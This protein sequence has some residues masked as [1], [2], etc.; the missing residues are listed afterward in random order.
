MLESTDGCFRDP[1]R[2]GDLLVVVEARQARRDFRVTAGVVVCDS[3][4][5]GYSC[6][7]M[8]EAFDIL[9]R[10]GVPRGGEVY[11]L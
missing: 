5:Q 6:R 9:R 11:F 10:D 7:C 1:P 8:C 3:L 4:G 2:I